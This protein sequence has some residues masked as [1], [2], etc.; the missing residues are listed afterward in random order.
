MPT[1]LSPLLAAI[2]LLV[3]PAGAVLPG[4]RPAEVA[5]GTRWNAAASEL[6]PM[7]MDGGA[8]DTPLFRFLL[9]RFDPEPYNQVRIEQRLIIRI[10]PRSAV[11]DNFAALAGP[12][13]PPR[14]YE[15]KAG[16]CLP[17]MG[18]AGVEVTDNRLVLY[19]RDRRT[20]SA[21]LEKSCH[22]RD[23]YSGFYVEQ[24]SDGQIC[25][26]RDE[27]HSRAGVTCSISALRELIPND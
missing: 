20:M 27:V 24:T 1:S 11:R 15:R 6:P 10:A 21:A 22:T 8:D 25:A 13:P 4:A 5:A 12:P 7:M 16:R 17:V 18:I 14:Y 2:A 23:F 9:G 3:P 26:G 19:M